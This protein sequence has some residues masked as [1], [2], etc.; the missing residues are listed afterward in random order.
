MGGGGWG[1]GEMC[2]CVRHEVL[3]IY[4]IFNSLDSRN[5]TLVHGVPRGTTCNPL[6]DPPLD[7][8]PR[9]EVVPGDG[10]GSNSH[11]VLAVVGKEPEPVVEE[12]KNKE[13]EKKR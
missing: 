4:S 5:K 8:A 6:H 13:E 3:H 10:G 9:N 11:S 12:G 7:G 1:V 2:C